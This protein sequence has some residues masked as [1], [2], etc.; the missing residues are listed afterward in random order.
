MF[1]DT[2][3]GEK[4]CYCNNCAI[5]LRSRKVD[6]RYAQHGVRQAVVAW[7]QQGALTV[8]DV[9]RIE[10]D[11]LDVIAKKFFNPSTSTFGIWS[12]DKYLI[13]DGLS[14]RILVDGQ[15]INFSDIESYKVFDNSIEY[16]VQSPNS[17]QYE[18]NTHHG[19]S[20]TIVGGMIAGPAG[21]IMGGLSAK[22]SLTVNEGIKTTYNTTVHDFTL[23]VYL[24]TFAFGG[25]IAFKLGTSEIDLQQ[26][27]NIFDK[28]IQH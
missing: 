9:E 14:Q 8:E 19:L 27:V 2:D 22:R 4:Y 25:S 16:N 24:K 11:S 18:L 1:Y 20:R 17:T 10:Q 12:L 21:A 5:R 23:L 6:P 7:L 13:V 15:Y 28:I 26:F 3:T